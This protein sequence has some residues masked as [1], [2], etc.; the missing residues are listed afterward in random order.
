MNGP[1]LW[2]HQRKLMATARNGP[3]TTG[4][5]S[6]RDAEIPDDGQG[7]SFEISGDPG[8]ENSREFAHV[9]LPLLIASN[10]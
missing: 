3:P 10:S 2:R 1:R 7:S 5:C 6:A 8:L 9:Q 4:C